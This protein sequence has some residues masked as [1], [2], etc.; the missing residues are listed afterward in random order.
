MLKTPPTTFFLLPKRL[1]FV[2]LTG[3]RVDRDTSPHGH[4]HN[5]QRPQVS[6]MTSNATVQNSPPNTT[7]TTTTPPPNQPA[8]RAPPPG[9]TYFPLGYKEAVSQWV[10]L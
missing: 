2:S 7:T 4:S 5:V 1:K 6:N 8:G 3:R 9:V 10:C